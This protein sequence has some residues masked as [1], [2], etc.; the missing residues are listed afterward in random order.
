M[1]EI[2]FR[3]KDIKTGIWIYGSLIINK[4]SGI[5]SIFQVDKKMVTIKNIYTV[6]EK[7]VGQYT[8]LKDKNGKE[9]Y[10]GDIAVHRDYECYGY[11]VFSGDESAF[12]FLVIT[13]SNNKGPTTE[14]E[15]LYDYADGL[16]IIG[17][18][19]ENPELLEVHHE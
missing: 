2:K 8:G 17:D 11:V 7:T 3:G 13:G 18:I 16:E 10:E 6:D 1:R 15:W 12:A 5:H 4:H 9:I 19:Y 14:F